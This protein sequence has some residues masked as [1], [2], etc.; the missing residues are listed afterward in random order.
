[1]LLRTFTGMYSYLRLLLRTFTGMYSYFWR[2]RMSINAPKWTF[3]IF[4][5]FF[6]CAF[7][8]TSCHP[9]SNV[10]FAF[11]INIAWDV[12]SFVCASPF[13]EACV[14]ERQISRVFWTIRNSRFLEVRWTEQHSEFI[15]L[16]SQVL[17]WESLV[18]PGFLGW[19]E[20]FCHTD[21]QCRETRQHVLP[22]TFTEN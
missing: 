11:E 14:S 17:T 1:M 5:F 22:F 7:F 12:R 2:W 19:L 8:M 4:C 13:P 16:S 3:H 6:L 10:A 15:L 20:D 21:T 9:F 18:L